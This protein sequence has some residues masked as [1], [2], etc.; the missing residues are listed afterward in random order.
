MSLKATFTNIDP[1]EFIYFNIFLKIVQMLNIDFAG[2]IAPQ[3]LM[4]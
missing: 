3:R 1:A 2:K 4:V